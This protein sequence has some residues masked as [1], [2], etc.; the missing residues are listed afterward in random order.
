[1][2]GTNEFSDRVWVQVARNGTPWAAIPLFLWL[3][4]AG[5]IYDNGFTMEFTLLQLPFII[6][7][8]ILIYIIA[9]DRVSK[10]VHV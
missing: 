3:L 4:Q 8:M 7:F 10:G 1:M 2:A 6:I 9:Y 5:A